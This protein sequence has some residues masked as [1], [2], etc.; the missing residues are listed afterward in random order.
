MSFWCKKLLAGVAEL[1]CGQAYV[2]FCCSIKGYSYTLKCII[3]PEKGIIIPPKGIIIPK[4]NHTGGRMPTTARVHKAAFQRTYPVIFRV[5][6][7]R[8]NLR[9]EEQ[10][11]RA[12]QVKFGKVE[13]AAK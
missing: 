6:H 3:I 8:F 10:L 2:F 12:K 1:H 9:L 11:R 5:P 7:L 4:Q 13:F